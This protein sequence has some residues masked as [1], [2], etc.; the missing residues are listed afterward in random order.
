[1]LFGPDRVETLWHNTQFNWTLEKGAIR[2]AK[3]LKNLP[4]RVDAACP[5]KV[6]PPLN[7]AKLRRIRRIGLASS[8]VMVPFMT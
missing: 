7:G 1:M 6:L 8:P 2:P 3:I 5:A 4:P